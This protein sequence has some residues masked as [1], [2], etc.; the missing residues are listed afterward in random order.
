MRRRAQLILKLSAVNLNETF[1]YSIGASDVRIHIG[2]GLGPLLIRAFR[3]RGRSCWRSQ[4][5]SDSQAD[6]LI[7]GRVRPRIRCCVGNNFGLWLFYY[8]KKLAN[9]LPSGN[10]V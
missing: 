6:L 4:N 10:F 8:F 1:R 2:S 9:R 5:Q 7:G 3:R